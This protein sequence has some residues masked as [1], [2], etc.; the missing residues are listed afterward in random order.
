MLF[1]VDKNDS[2]QLVDVKGVGNKWRSD[3]LQE[4]IVIHIF[5]M[6]L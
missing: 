2:L 4:S 1:L 3:R 5:V 6:I